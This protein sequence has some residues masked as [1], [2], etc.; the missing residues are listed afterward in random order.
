MHDDYVDSDGLGGLHDGI[1]LPRYQTFLVVPVAYV[2]MAVRFV[3]TG[4]LAARGELDTTPTELADLDF[5]DAAPESESEVAAPARE[6]EDPGSDAVTIDDS[7][8]AVEPLPEPRTE[9][10][11]DSPDHDPEEEVQ[12]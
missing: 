6:I 7:L 1:D 2:L 12:S 3:S 4:V 5:G 11:P 8:G 10:L 9:E